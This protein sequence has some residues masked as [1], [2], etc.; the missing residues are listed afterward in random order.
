MTS[1]QSVLVTGSSR[2]IGK[3]IAL[4]AAGDGAGEILVASTDTE[5]GSASEGWA[6]FY[7]PLVGPRLPSGADVTG[8]PPGPTHPR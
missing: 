5:D 8:P 6:L 7:G 4:R 2:G 3:A 1:Q